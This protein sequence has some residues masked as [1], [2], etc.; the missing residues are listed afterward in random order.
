MV[1][2]KQEPEVQAF[3]SYIL[4]YHM[5]VFTNFWTTLFVVLCICVWVLCMYSGQ[6]T[7][8]KI[9]LADDAAFVEK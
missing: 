6:F 7:Y 4:I 8:A 3:F 2:Q 1:Q 9:F 5:E